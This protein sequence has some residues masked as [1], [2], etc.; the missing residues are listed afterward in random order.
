MIDNSSGLRYFSMED[1]K[2]A[3]NKELEEIEDWIKFPYLLFIIMSRG[4]FNLVCVRNLYNIPKMW[5]YI[6]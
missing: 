4:I 5:Y 1:F 6:Y 3:I 2:K